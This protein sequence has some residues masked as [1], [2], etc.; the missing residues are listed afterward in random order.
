[1]LT[2]CGTTIEPIPDGPC[3]N[4]PLFENVEKDTEE[5]MRSVLNDPNGDPVLQTVFRD[6]IDTVVANNIT[7]DEFARKLEVR[8]GC[9]ELSP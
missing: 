4:L 9:T 3:P 6:L 8:A 5:Y 1:M 2:S 7:W